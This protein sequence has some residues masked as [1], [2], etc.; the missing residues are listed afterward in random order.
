[1]FLENGFVDVYQAQNNKG[2]SL[3]V[4]PLTIAIYTITVSH[5]FVSISGTLVRGTYRS[6]HPESH[7]LLSHQWD[8]W[9]RAGA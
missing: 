4:H 5:R 3:L 6:V 9:G 8:A 2:M 1:M 7:L